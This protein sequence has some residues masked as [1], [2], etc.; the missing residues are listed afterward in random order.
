MFAPVEKILKKLVEKKILTTAQANDARATIREHGEE[1]VDNILIEKFKVAKKEILE[2]DGQHIGHE[3]LDL[4]HFE[5]DPKIVKIIPR[6]IAEKYTILLIAKEDPGNKLTLAMGNPLNLFAIDDIKTLTKGT[7]KAVLADEALITKKLPALYAALESANEIIDDMTGGE[8]EEDTQ[9]KAVLDEE[10]LST[11]SLAAAADDAPIVRLGNSIIMQAI[12]DG[13]SD[14]HVEPLKTG[15]RIRFRVDGMLTE[16]MRFPRKLHAPL[17]SRFK[18]LAKLDIAERR[19][20][21]DGRIPL[22]VEGREVDLRVATV[23]TVWGEKVTMRILDKSSILI[24][25]ERLGFEHE[26]LQTFKKLI[27]KPYGIIFATGPTGSGKT[28]TLYACLNEL[29]NIEKNLISIEDPIEY[30][31]PGIAQAQVNP[32]AGMTF[33]GGLRAMLRQD[34][35]IVMV[36]ELRDLETAEVAVHA[37]LTGHLVLATI[38]ANDTASTITRLFHMGIEPYLVASSVVCIVAQRL[39]RSLCPE[40]KVDYIPPPEALQRLGIPPGTRIYRGQ[41]CEFCRQTGYQG[42][43][44]VYEMMEI[45]DELRNLITSEASAPEIRRKSTELGMY[46]LQQDGI[47]KVIKGQ[48]SIEEAMRVLF[49]A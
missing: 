39:I 23:P 19:A 36:G 14:I 45:D 35:D 25:L 22:R 28:T 31:L 17:I 11:G 48:T 5:I 40:C 37:S 8:V 34:P 1:S 4:E 44:G 16:A 15:V 24:G 38:H 32:K 12:K 33:A 6:H 13:A 27:D 3:F 7:I 47:R 2:I 43:M 41:G 49:D 18:L 42:R 29:N 21:Q 26:E 30:Q 20:P 9:M 10:N 46:T